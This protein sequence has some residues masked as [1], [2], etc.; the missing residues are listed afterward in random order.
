MTPAQLQAI[1]RRYATK[2]ELR[3]TTG[4]IDTLWQ[5]CQRRKEIDMLLADIAA[6]ERL[7]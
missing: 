3:Y 4:A 1:R 6:V 2:P 5:Q 7:K